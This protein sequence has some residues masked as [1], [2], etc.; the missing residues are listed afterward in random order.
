[1]AVT[2]PQLCNAEK[3][4]TALNIKVDRVVD[5]AE[6]LGEPIDSTTRP[7]P[8]E[9]IELLG[10]EFNATVTV[11]HPTLAACVHASPPPPSLSRLG[12]CLDVCMHSFD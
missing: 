2:V 3:L 8:A 6:E 10:L 7:L 5:M 4:A 12:V 9:L 11:A 1:M